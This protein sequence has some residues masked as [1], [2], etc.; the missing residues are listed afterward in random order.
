MSFFSV[1]VRLGKSGVEE[2]LPLGTLSELE[3]ANLA[4]LKDPLS[5]QISKGVAFAQQ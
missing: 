1:P 4:D 5:T 2:I 3:K